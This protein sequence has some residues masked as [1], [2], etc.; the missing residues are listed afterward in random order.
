GVVGSVAR[1]PHRLCTGGL[2]HRI[3]ARRCRRWRSARARGE[4]DCAAARR[5]R[6]V[7]HGWNLHAG[8]CAVNAIE[9]HLATRR[10]AGLFDF[11]FMSLLEID[12][13]AALAFLEWLQTRSLAKLDIG[14][15]VYTLLLNNDASVFVDATLWRL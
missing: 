11:S 9:Q 5:G 3:R 15:S 4:S 8:A 13:P 7:R 1:C 14:R 2:G 6:F 12:G 10:A